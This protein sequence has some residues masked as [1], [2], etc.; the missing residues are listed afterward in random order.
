MKSKAKE[1]NIGASFSLHRCSELEIDKRRCLESALRDLGLRH[2]RLMTYWNIHEPMPGKYNFSELDW[3]IKLIAKYEGTISLCLGKRQPRWPECHMPEWA[4]K[5]SQEEWREALLTYINTVVSRYKDLP[6]IVSWQLENE[7][8]LKAFG[9]CPDQDYSSSRLRNEFA[10]VQRLDPNRPVI[11]SL[12]NNW[13]IP[14]QRPIPD[15]F[16][17]SIYTLMSYGGKEVRRSIFSPAWH[18]F[19]AKLLWL[20]FRRTTMIHE[21]QTEPWL[22][23]PVLSCKTEY[24]HAQ[25]GPQ[26]FA[27]TVE[28]A[29]KTGIE[30]AD[31][32]GLEYWYW[33]KANRHD[34]RMWTEAKKIIREN[35]SVS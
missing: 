3:Q 1:L 5:L 8:K 6:V 26:H 30:S 11:M 35:Y 22:N 27:A 24:L 7:A 33:L 17:I 15:I 12:S 32:W 13:G 10:L 16:G 34:N 18:R 21:L 31:L 9:H 20:L 4:Q 25:F 14:F 19:R 23:K 29:K 28:F 2:F